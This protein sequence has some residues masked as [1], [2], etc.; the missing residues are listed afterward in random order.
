MTTTMT[1]EPQDAGVQRTLRDLVLE[2]GLHYE[3]VIAAAVHRDLKA[4]KIGR[5]W[6]TTAADLQDWR[7][8]VAAR[9][10]VVRMAPEKGA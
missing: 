10:G 3:D 1:D 2:T 7:D 6:V 9:G 4:T 8:D 5:S